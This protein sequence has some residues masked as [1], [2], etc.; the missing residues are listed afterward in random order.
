[1][2]VALSE[3][4]N[5]SRIGDYLIHDTIGKGAYGQVRL[6]VNASSSARCAIKIL[7]KSSK[8]VAQPLEKEILIHRS[9]PLNSNIIQLY[10]VKEDSENVYLVMELAEGG[11]LFGRIEPDIGIDEEI[12]HFYFCQLLAAIVC[13]LEF[14]D[15]L[16]RLGIA[17]RDLKPENLL[18]D[19]NGN[20]KLSDFGFAT[21]FLHKGQRR[22]LNTPCGSSVYMAPEVLNASYDGEQVD[23]WSAGVILYVMVTGSNNIFLLK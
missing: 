21:V 15:H 9:I 14:Q 19:Q 12:A 7:K 5:P 23:L 4:P 22:T 6:A 18:L 20:L 3:E 8:V 13:L 11:E 1:M 2:T 10:E 17:H 16:H